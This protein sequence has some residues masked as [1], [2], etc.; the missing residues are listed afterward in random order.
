[1]KGTL[2]D[3]SPTSLEGRAM[4]CIAPKKTDIFWDILEIGNQIGIKLQIGM[5]SQNACMPESSKHRDGDGKKSTTK[6]YY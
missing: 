4:V 2:L 1:M 5:K 6:S 3:L